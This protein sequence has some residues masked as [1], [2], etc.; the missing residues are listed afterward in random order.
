[1]FDATDAIAVTDADSILTYVS[2]ACLP[3]LGYAPEELVGKPITALVHPEDRALVGTALQRA[4]RADDTRTVSL[5][6]RR[7]DGSYAWIESRSRS[8]VDPVTGA[9]RETHAVMRDIGDMKAAQLAIERQ[10]LTDPLTGL[11]NRLLLADRLTQ[12]LKRLRRSPGLVGVLMLDVDRFKVINDTLGHASGD[13]VL[14]ALARRLQRLARPE[15]TVARFGGDEFVIVVQGLAKPDDLSAF[16]GRIVSGLREPNHI[17]GQEVATT[18]SVG[19]ASTSHPDRPTGDLL[20]EADVALYRAKHRGRDRHEI[21]GA[22]LQAQAA[23]RVETER[24]LRRALTD[25][26]VAVAYQPIVDLATGRTAGLEALLRITDADLG[27]VAPERFLWVAQEAGLMPAMGDWMR[28]TALSQL[29]AW[30][31]DA[32]SGAGQRIAVNVTLRELAVAGFTSRLTACLLAAG[33]DGSDLALEVTEHVLSQASN[34]VI[35]SLESLRELGVHIGLDDFG[36]GSSALSYLQTFPL[37]YI[38]IDLSYIARIP[39]DARTTSIVVAL[40][41][42]AHALDLGVVA[43]GVEHADQLAALRRAGCDR[44]QGFLFS[45]P[46]TA[47][48]FEAHLKATTPLLLRGRRRLR[49][50]R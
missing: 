32:R 39:G 41:G 26:H 3:L 15:D 47:A 37:D 30:R 49:M 25:G 50:R 45:R 42:L 10:A 21:Y 28:A 40:I 43:E 48:G 2:A 34:S 35:A 36:T 9:V 23:E 20:H 13:A 44:A 22:A 16:A 29:S 1:M 12:S 46:L 38:K 19:I 18:V 11:A 17:A 27:P 7:K 31:S 4:A 14:R 33:L 6:Y 24:V 5:R 8:I